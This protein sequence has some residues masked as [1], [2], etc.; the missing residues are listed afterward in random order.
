MKEL[1]A[2]FYCADYINRQ[3]LVTAFSHYFKQYGAKDDD[4]L[5]LPP[6][7]GWI[8]FG[9][10]SGEIQVMMQSMDERSI[11]NYGAIHLP[12]HELENK[13]RWGEWSFQLRELMLE[14]LRVAGFYPDSKG[15]FL[16]GCGEPATELECG[17][18]KCS[19]CYR[20]S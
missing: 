5:N 1:G 17:V 19:T 6:V 18:Q 3:R 7:I 12:L 11:A 14:S 4:V 20:Q 16:C 9:R 15:K 10:R 8:R 2:A 13:M